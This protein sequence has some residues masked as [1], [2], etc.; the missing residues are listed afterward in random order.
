MSSDLTVKHQI[1]DYSTKE[2]AND[3]TNNNSTTLTNQYFGTAIERMHT[4]NS[5]KIDIDDNNNGQQQDSLPPRRFLY[6]IKLKAHVHPIRFFFFLFSIFTSLAVIVYFAAAQ[7]W[8]LT[9]ILGISD[10]V[11]D[12]TGS[13]STYSE[14][15]SI[16]FVVAWGVMSDHIQK[17]TIITISLIIIGVI[18]I[19]YGFAPNLYP[20]LLILRLIYSVGTAGTT[21]MMASM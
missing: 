3:C 15:S 13:L 5:N 7:S 21:C 9:S 4:N 14:V 16:I 6:F 18:C 1:S 19:A 8:V 2:I 10:N 17:R 11:G 20:T 12:A